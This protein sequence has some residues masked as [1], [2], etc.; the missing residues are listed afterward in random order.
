LA[1][2]YC[3]CCRIVLPAIFFKYEDIRQKRIDGSNLAFCLGCHL[4]K[5]LNNEQDHYKLFKRNIMAT[6]LCE[7]DDDGNEIWNTN[8]LSKAQADFKNKK[9]EQMA[10]DLDFKRR[11]ELKLGYDGEFRD[12]QKPLTPEEL[13]GK[14]CAA[15][16]RSPQIEDKLMFEADSW[17]E[18]NMA[19]LNAHGYA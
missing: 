18:T 16:M 2:H 11:E 13:R 5:Y 3:D 9:I 7:V 15:K 17:N 6:W 12:L 1:S 4:D 14:E 10:W 19:R 8:D